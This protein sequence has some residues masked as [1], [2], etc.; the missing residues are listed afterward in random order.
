MFSASA[1][2]LENSSILVFSVGIG[3]LCNTE[4]SDIVIHL[5]VC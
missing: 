3:V 2:I 1:N 4:C 5:A